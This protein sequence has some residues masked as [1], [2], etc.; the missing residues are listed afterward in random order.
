[1]DT[2]Q[3]QSIEI[4]VRGKLRSARIPESFI[5]QQAEDLVQQA[6]AEY[7]SASERGIKITNA[8]GWI[9]NTAYRR[10]IDQLRHE[11]HETEGTTEDIAIE[12]TDDTAPLPDE[13]A[14][15]HIEVEQ[16]HRAIA[17]LS[18]TQ[19]QAL[20]LY[21]FENRTTR[22]GAKALG[23]SEP[24]FRRRRDAAIHNL[25]KRLGV[26]VPEFDIGLAAWLSLTTTDGRFTSVFSNL[27]GATESV[28][29]GAIAA[30]ERSREFATRLLSSGGG[31][32]AIGIGSPAS[33][34]AAGICAT[35]IAACT[36]TGVIG[37]GV[38]GVDLIKHANPKPSVE[39][40][41]EPSEPESS[42]P[43]AASTA[44]TPSQESSRAS[45]SGETNRGRSNKSSTSETSS[46]Q[47]RTRQVR[48]SA[49]SQFSVESSA[50]ATP[51]E[52]A[53]DGVPTSP[54]PTPPSASPTPDQAAQQQF[55]LP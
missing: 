13:E 48:Q 25:R 38:A 8:S 21:Y 43:Q 47:E 50:S 49:S 32:T 18:T 44:S 22:D 17:R 5:D 10:A 4:G 53:A 54:P 37:P 23:W 45:T 27:T 39:K 36:A 24:T 1:M 2:D 34:A 31:E 55:G 29:S 12:A 20:S 6:V 3:L 15:D 7:A 46:K 41:M 35:A 52:S 51:A 42:R 30:I 9:V 26:T 14:L 16:L 28:R 19:K 11:Q 40:R 33:K